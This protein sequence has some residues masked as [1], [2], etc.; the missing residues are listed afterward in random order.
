MQPIGFYI[1]KVIAFLLMPLSVIFTLGVV[2]YAMLPRNHRARRYLGSALVLLF[3]LSYAPLADKLIDPLESRYPTLPTLPAKTRYIVVLG[4]A[5]SYDP[6]LSI[7]SQ[8][9]PE[10]IVRLSE[11]IR[12][13]RQHPK[14]V[15]LILSGYAGIG[16]NVSHARLLSHLASDL[17]IPNDKIV[18]LEK[19]ANTEQEAKA[20]APIV[21]NRPTVLVT[22]AYHMPR[23]MQAFEAQGLHPLPAPT[24]K[25]AKPN[26]H[27]WWRILDIPALHRSMLAWHEYLGLLYLMLRHTVSQPATP[28]ANAAS[29]PAM[30][31]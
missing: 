12:L 5:S 21:G 17:G 8:L 16:G 30:S 25:L 23:A 3:A 24:Y 22:S 27:H 14:D 4:S 2:A 13:Y 31:A 9:S 19:P 26:Q 20:V 11:A 15:T 29:T 6:S 28:K 18:L 1:V 10:A 7:T